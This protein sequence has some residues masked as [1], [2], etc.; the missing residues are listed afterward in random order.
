MTI[1]KFFNDAF[2]TKHSKYKTLNSK[3]EELEIE[4]GRASS[5]HN[6]RTQM[7][8]LNLFVHFNVRVD[9]RDKFVVTMR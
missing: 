7:L 8:K 3:S 5:N 1:N 2:N 9:C 6:D 4:G